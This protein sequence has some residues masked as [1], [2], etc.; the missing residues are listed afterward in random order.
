MIELTRINGSALVVNSELIQYAE[1]TPDTT[2]TLLNG[3]KVV[4]RERPAEVINLAVAYRARVMGEAAKYSL[5]GTELGSG[6][7]PPALSAKRSCLADGTIESGV[8]YA[9]RRRAIQD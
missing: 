1:S 3:E 8:S 5:R 9:S 6:A 4:V 2:L 7:A